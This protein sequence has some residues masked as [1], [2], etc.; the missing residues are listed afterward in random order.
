MS[1]RKRGASALLSWV[2]LLASPFAAA[3]IWRNHFDADGA[4]RPPAFLDFVVLGAPGKASWM[5]IADQN[6]PSA[7]NQVTQTSKKRPADSIA[8]ALRR[9]VA[10]TDGKISVG[11]KKQPSRAGLVFRMAGEKDFLALLVDC[12]SGETR[13]VAWRDGAPEELARGTATIEREWGILSVSLAGP[14][15]SARWNDR[16]LLAARDQKP[17]QG[18]VGLATEG[19]GIASFDE[20]VIDD[21]KP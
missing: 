21:G 17:V 14:A 11:L 1:N 3:E 18:R 2:L 6:P 13:L 5:V 19:A 15:I 10:L 8:A 20:L 16:E 4:A 9:N 12:E 7:P